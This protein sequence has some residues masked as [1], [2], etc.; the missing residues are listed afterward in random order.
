MDITSAYAGLAL[1]WPRARCV[2]ERLTPQ[3]VSH[4]AFPFGQLR[5]VQIAGAPVLA[6]R[7]TYVGELGWE[8]HE[9]VEFVATPYAALLQ[10]C[11]QVRIANAGY[12][13]NETVPLEAG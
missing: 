1:M 12:P 9:L 2:R 6:L 8:L 10:G 4:A 11:A 3:D 5:R 7:C 13:A